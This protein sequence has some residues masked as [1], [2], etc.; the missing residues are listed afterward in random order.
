[1][2]LCIL[3][4]FLSMT[5][6]SVSDCKFFLAC[7]KWQC[8]KISWPFLF[9]ESNPT[10]PLINSLEW[11]CWKIRFREDIRILRL[12]IR[13][14]AVLVSA[15]SLISQISRRK[16]ILQ[17]SHFC[18]FLKGPGGFDWWKKCQKISLHY[19]FKAKWYTF[20]MRTKTKTCKK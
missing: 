15:E 1:M 5:A 17:Q 11:F 7:L 12:K 16:R 18:R 8:H 2:E 13:L 4:C 9:H 14:R 10:G 19:N 6:I 20:A 3:R